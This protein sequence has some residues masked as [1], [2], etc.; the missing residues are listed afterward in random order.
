MTPEKDKDIVFAMNT[1]DHELNETID[2][3]S[4]VY[5]SALK[6]LRM[7][8]AL[9][10]DKGFGIAQMGVLTHLHQEGVTTATGIAKYLRIRPQS[11]TRLLAGLEKQGYINRRQD[12]VDRRQSLIEITKSGSRLLIKEGR[13]QREKL[14]QIIKGTLT[15]AEKKM[16]LVAAQIMDQLSTSAEKEFS[17]IKHRKK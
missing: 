4:Q 12:K 3:A 9:P 1:Q 7:L 15:D 10:S 14:A 13:G 5:R 2:T 11:V 17:D 8:R 6:L 16:L